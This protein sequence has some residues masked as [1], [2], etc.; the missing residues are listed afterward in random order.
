[1]AHIA[2]ALCNPGEL[3]LVP[4]PGYQIFSAGPRLCDAE[5]WEYPLLEE[6]QFLP[7]LDEIPEEI[8]RRARYMVVS[9]PANPICRTA[10]ESFYRDLIAFAKK[11]EIIILHDNAYSDIIYDGRRGG[12]FLEYKGAK[13]VGIEFYSLSKSFNYTGARLS[14]AV[15]NRAVIQKFKALRTQFDYGI[16]LPVQYG[17]IAALTGPFDGVR[18]AGTMR[19]V[20]VHSAAGCAVSAGMF[21]IARGQCSYGRRYRRATRI[22]RTFV[23]S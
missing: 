17:A 7:Q 20:T 23:W 15:G 13:E 14:F 8:A 19:S 9:Y 11:Y 5:V 10:P 16:F 4:N 3:V 1:M 6:H 2:W 21:R 12:S 22:L 18:S